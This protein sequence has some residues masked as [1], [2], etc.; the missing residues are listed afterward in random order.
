MP[1]HPPTPPRVV[2]RTSAGYYES[3]SYDLGV[4]AVLRRRINRDSV[5]SQP[6]APPARR[7]ASHAASRLESRVRFA[8]RASRYA[9]TVVIGVITGA[10]AWGV[11]AATMQIV[12][13]QSALVSRYYGDDARATTTVFFVT[14]ATLG[15]VGGWMA[16]FYAPAASGG[17]VTQVMATLNGARVPGLLSGRTLAAK[18]VGVIAGVGSALAIGPEGP[19]VHIGAGI[20]SV[21]ALYWPRKFLCEDKEEAEASRADALRRR[22][23]E[24]ASSSSEDGYTDDDYSDERSESGAWASSESDDEE[25]LDGDGAMDGLLAESRRRRARRR[26]APRRQRWPRFGESQ[27]LD[28]VLL[29]L[30]APSTHRD[31]VS[32]GAAAGL[33]AAFGAPIGGVL[34]SFEEASTYWSQR[35]MWRCLICAAIASFVLALLDLRGNP[36]MVFIT[37]D[38]LRPTTP[39]DYFHQLPFFVI[40]AAL[41][42]LTGVTFNKIQA[43]TSRFRPAPKHKIARLFECVAVVL[44][45]VGIRFAASAFAGQCMAPPD[46]WVEDGF[47][48]RFNCPEGEINDIATVFFVYP[49]RAIGWMF[50]MA[51]H[52]WGEAYG[53]TA[54]GLGIAA[55]CYLV[56]M[57]LAFGIAVPGGLFMPSLFLGACTGAC[58]G[59]ML[60]AALPESWD[61]QPGIYA[62]IG[63]TSALGG[64]FRSSVSLVVIMVE[65]TNGQA[66]VFA[67]IVA[68]IV[69]NLVGNYFAHG[70]YHAELSR[71]KT[72]AY[73]PRDPSSS[74]DGKTA[75]D[76]MATPAAF[77]PEI[78]FRDAVK[79][80]LEHTTHNGFPV[81]DDRGKL[82][83]LI[84]RSQLEVLLAAR[85]RDAA[86]SASET[87]QSRLD[88]EMRTAH[89]QR[90][91]RG[92]TPGVAAGLLDET[93]DD[94]EVERIM[95]TNSTPRRPVDA[96]ADHAGGDFASPLVD[97]RTY[98]NPAPLAV[99]LDYPADRAHGV[100]LSLALRHLPVID[101]EH[102]VRGIIT[103][104]DL[105]D[106]RP[107]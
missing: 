98:M 97:I 38:S 30:A 27:K 78:A 41:A 65:S 76:V 90:V 10:C 93:L 20:A 46:A 52:V 6:R 11:S 16:I 102:I 34:F 103:R 63:A 25:I 66:F 77:L 92:A 87:T 3:I 53:F 17:G 28:A 60:K 35:T 37:G 45:T 55:A 58:S 49:G 104:K 15:L 81:V 36:G 39:R 33:A 14:S 85:P 73:L 43:W 1:D 12:T 100:F 96:D 23:N 94:I 7:V 105:I 4:N 79:S 51:E 56:M 9:L 74:L 50:G 26:A 95:R 69:S 82:S 2:R 31:F 42:G 13:M 62:L 106:A 88:L 54:Q 59:L 86:P 48:V 83:G 70:I 44:A 57:A 80:L 47:G 68:V 22:Y 64:V 24:T 29:D 40:V 67:I 107:H 8:A 91:T 19:M 21:C 101:D 5:N 89:I 32:A 75:A 72:V 99:P 61:I 18:I 84:L 71:S